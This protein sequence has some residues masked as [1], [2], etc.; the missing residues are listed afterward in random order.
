MLIIF[1]VTILDVCFVQTGGHAVF[2]KKDGVW[3]SH[4]YITAVK[5]LRVVT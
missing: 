2:P 5:D 1:I 4:S 3:D